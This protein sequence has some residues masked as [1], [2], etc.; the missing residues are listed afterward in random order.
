MRGLLEALDG[1]HREA[2]ESPDQVR[3]ALTAAELERAK[4]DGVLGM[5]PS[6][7]GA[8]ALR[9]SLGVLRNLYRLGLR[10]LGI[11]WN[12]RNE[13]ADGAAENGSGGGLTR[14]GIAVVKELN[15][16]GMLVD[17]S[18]LSDAGTRDVLRAS[19]GPVIAS[20]SNARAVTDHVRNLP[21]WAIE[22]I[23][24]SGGVVGLASFGDFVHPTEP[25]MDRLLAHVDHL[26]R[27][28]GVESIA[29]GPDFTDYVPHDS[30]SAANQAAGI[31]SGSR[32][33]AEGLETASQAHT[34]T[35]ALLDRGYTEDECAAILGGNYLRVCRAVLG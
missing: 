2:E 6:L 23:A 15:R 24:Q 32:R 3:I 9:G 25:T 16:L 19:D 29:L 17:V 4:A 1:L 11:T 14:F 8:G 10:A 31:Y 13:L 21:D 27:L 18:H 20:H 26:R 7:E 28:V 30:L 35:A 22:G 33:Y 5:L 12:Y 34:F